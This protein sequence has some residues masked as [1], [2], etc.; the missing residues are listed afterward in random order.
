MLDLS[1]SGIYRLSTKS[2]KKKKPNSV[3]DLSAAFPGEIVA[4]LGDAA[5]ASPILGVTL[6]E[7]YAGD[8]ELTLS[9]VESGPALLRAPRID[10][11][12]DENGSLLCAPGLW[13]YD[14][15]ATPIV[16]RRW[17]R[18]GV[19]IS[20]E[21]G[22][23]Y[24]LTVADEGMG[25]AHEETILHADGEATARATH[26]ATPA[27]LK[28]G[29]D[30]A[31]NKLTP[32]P[33]AFVAAPGFTIACRIHPET[34]ASGGRY[35][36]G[37]YNSGLWIDGGN[38]GRLTFRQYDG[39]AIRTAFAMT[40]TFVQNGPPVSIIAS[41]RK[42]G[43][44]SGHALKLWIDGGLTRVGSASSFVADL[45]DSSLGI[46]AR[47]TSGHFPGAFEQWLWSAPYAL[48]PDDPNV[49]A[50]FFDGA[51]GHAARVLPENGAVTIGGVAHAP[52]LFLNGARSWRDGGV[53]FGS[54][55]GVVELAGPELEV[56]A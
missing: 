21:T 32:P 15:A 41:A 54:A 51:N 27:I 34:F 33:G 52:T 46:G 3:L 5:Q 11:P 48:D 49:A 26:R 10:A 24:T 19:P 56:S 45:A 13:V 2:K 1:L 14:P 42:D 20:G 39:T 43:F 38:G 37:G 29:L 17:L 44:A 7:S 47:L 40:P 16:T 55:G 12:Q 28:F 30:G 36:Y 8:Y 9:A 53:N 31:S 23:S 6:P 35:I 18:N 25:I 4:T 22:L 50:A